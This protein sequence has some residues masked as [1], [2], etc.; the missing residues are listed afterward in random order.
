MPKRLE[1]VLKRFPHQG[2]QIEEEILKNREFRA[3]CEDYSDAVDAF[4]RWSISCDNVAPER[5]S[6]YR[7]L[8]GDLEL[9]ICEHLQTQTRSGA[10]SLGRLPH[11]RQRE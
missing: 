1:A 5:A 10:H 8:V 3:L 7:R 2:V 6:E 9:E 11:R 4:D